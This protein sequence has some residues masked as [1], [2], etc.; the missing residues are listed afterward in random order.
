MLSPEFLREYWAEVAAAPIIGLATTIYGLIV[1]LVPYPKLSGLFLF[2]SIEITSP[3]PD[4]TLKDKQ[5][6][7]PSRSYEVRGSF[8]I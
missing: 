8:E 6:C 2:R 4:E 3:R 1:A 7:G 5:P